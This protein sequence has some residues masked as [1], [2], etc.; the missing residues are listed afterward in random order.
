MAG[1][2]G[3]TLN[4]RQGVSGVAHKVSLMAVRYYS[5]SNSGTLNLRNSIQALHYAIENGARIINYSGGG[6]EFSKAEY[7]AIKRAEQKGILIVAAA[8]NERS[9]I[10]L[11]KNYYYPSATVYQILFRWQLLI[12]IT[13]SFV[14]RTGG[15][16][17]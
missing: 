11:A 7:D 14:P 3:A 15:S 1:I 12:S 13:A 10:D 4:R 5:Q 9:N 8:G 2:I 6:P 17:R 16:K